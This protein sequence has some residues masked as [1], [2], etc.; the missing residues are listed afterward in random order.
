M[1]TVWANGSDTVAN[2]CACFRT[3]MEAAGV[4]TSERIIPDGALHRIHVE[5]DKRGRRSGWYVLHTDQTPA[6]TFGC[7]RL[8]VNEQWRAE[9]MS[10]TARPLD[11]RDDWHIRDF[12]DKERQVQLE[13]AAD[14]A[15]QLWRQARHVELVD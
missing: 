11:R 13:H 9:S 3:A 8:G 15:L 1:T 10:S 12:R 5:G 4:R 2:V 6:G 7:F 14:R